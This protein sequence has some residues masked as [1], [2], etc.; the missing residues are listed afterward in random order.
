ME[1]NIHIWYTS[2]HIICSSIK[3]CKVMS[4]IPV[5]IVLGLTFA[6]HSSNTRYSLYLSRSI[7]IWYAITWIHER[8]GES[9]YNSSHLQALGCLR[10]T[11]VFRFMTGHSR[12]Y[13]GKQKRQLE[14][15]KGEAMD[16]GN[17]R[18]IGGNCRRDWVPR[19]HTSVF[20][21]YF[22]DPEVSVASI[23]PDCRV[24]DWGR[25]A[26]DDD[27]D[28]E[29]GFPLR[30]SSTRADSVTPSQPYLNQHRSCNALQANELSTG[31]RNNNDAYRDS[32]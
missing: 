22:L 6:I 31:G 28:D 26:L 5:R 16:S 2:Y 25:I 29:R 14:T 30:V 21:T 8:T 10:E 32:R 12:Y 4:L 9:T 3:V 18:R 19:D 1:E 23:D 27:G 7:A 13:N 24:W 17:K 11:R 15:H 20:R